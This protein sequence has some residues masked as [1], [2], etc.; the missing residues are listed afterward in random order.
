MATNNILSFA[1]DGGAL[2]LSQTDYNADAQ[3]TI[4]NQ[5]GVAR[6]DFV[7]KALRQAIA[8]ARGLAQFIAD[9]QA[10]NVDDTLLAAAF[11]TMISNAVKAA[12]ASPAGTIVFVPAITPLAGTIKVN[13]A[14]LSRATYSRLWTFAQASGNISADDGSW[15]SGGFSPGDGT[16]TFR[17]PDYRGY[18]LRMWDD[19]RGVDVGRAIGSVQA[20]QLLAHSH[21]VT[22]PG[23]NHTISDPG[24]A[25]SGVP[26]RTSNVDRGT[27]SSDYSIDS[28]GATNPNSTGITINNRVTGISINNSSGGSEVRVK[29]I[30]LMPL[31]YI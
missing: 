12:A 4:G 8:V 29:T 20:D 22:D 17:I 25:H 18:H 21:G 6:A 5:P 27:N 28:S 23:H 15:I 3:R 2:V 1:Q 14:L 10:T 7:N 26:D 9:N 30:A 13:G 19:G 11:S 24:H 31:I 16:T